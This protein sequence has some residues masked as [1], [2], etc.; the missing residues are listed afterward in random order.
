MSLYWTL[1][2]ADCKPGEWMPKTSVMTASLPCM[3]CP[4]GMKCASGNEAVPCPVGTISLEKNATQC[5]HRNITCPHGYAV[6]NANC[7]CVFITCPRK[8]MV[9][10]YEMHCVDKCEKTQCK[11]VDR[12]CKCAAA[13][14]C[15][16]GTWWQ[17]AVDKFMCLWL[18]KKKI[19]TKINFFFL[20]STINHRPKSFAA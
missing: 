15:D 16:G 13:V 7:E 17:P 10:R 8:L 1:A 11:T 4:V 3:P 18:E 19:L 20:L 6:S 9:N 12:E 14:R 5:C 2:M